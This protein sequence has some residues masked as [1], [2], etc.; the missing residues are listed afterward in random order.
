VAGGALAER[1]VEQ[2]DVVGLVAGG[3]QRGVAVGH[4]GHAVALALERAGE[5]VAQRAV[6]VDQQDVQRRDGL[7]PLRVRGLRLVKVC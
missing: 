5:H 2:D 7:H 4:G 1:D 3:L 6:V